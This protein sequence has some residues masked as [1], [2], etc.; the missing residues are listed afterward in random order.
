MYEV[1]RKA[2]LVRAR[3]EERL[4]S[5]LFPLLLLDMLLQLLLASVHLALSDCKLLLEPCELVVDFPGRSLSIVC[6]AEV[7]NGV[8]WILSYRC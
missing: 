1:L 6:I 7:V 5:L 8:V 2:F 3:A 4:F